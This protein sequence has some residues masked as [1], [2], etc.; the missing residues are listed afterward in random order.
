MRPPYPLA[1]LLVSA[2]EPTLD[3]QRGDC[4]MATQP[5]GYELLLPCSLITPL[6]TSDAPLNY[7]PASPPLAAPSALSWVLDA[8]PPPPGATSWAAV[9]RCHP[10]GA[11]APG[12][13]PTRPT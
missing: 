5:R 2:Q 11:R 6:P 8:P 12:P 10:R 7:S 1:T 4:V 13:V 3:V 9:S